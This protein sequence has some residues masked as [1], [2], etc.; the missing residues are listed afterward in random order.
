[1]LKAN[2]N[3][4]T[5]LWLLLATI[6]ENIIT[7]MIPILHNFLVF[8]T[9]CQKGNSLYF[10][11]H[12]QIYKMYIPRQYKAAAQHYFGDVGIIVTTKIFNL[13]NSVLPIC[14]MW[15]SRRHQALTDPARTKHAYVIGNFQQPSITLYEL[16]L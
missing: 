7:L 11:L 12:F 15:E 1:M 2:Y 13:S 5:F 4:K 10:F 9:L 6:F 3:Q 8:V 14:I 16:Y